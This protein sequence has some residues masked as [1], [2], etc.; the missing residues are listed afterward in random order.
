MNAI[1]LKVGSG[2]ARQQ[3][4]VGMRIVLGLG[5]EL[6]ED[7]G[8]A[9]A[10]P[11]RRTTIHGRTNEILPLG[12]GDAG[13]PKRGEDVI[14]HRVDPVRDR[15][16]GVLGGGEEVGETGH[17]AHV[18][19]G[20]DASQALTEDLETGALDNLGRRHV[21]PIATGSGVHV[22]LHVGVPHEAEDQLARH[23]GTFK[24]DNN[25]NSDVDFDFKKQKNNRKTADVGLFICERIS[26]CQIVSS[27]WSRDNLSIKKNWR[28]K[29]PQVTHET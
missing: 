22:S 6:A 8:E 17:D 15:L 24:V 20:F 25:S 11:K 23:G 10:V 13:L 5:R 2:E 18:G 12:V 16:R 29:S 19:L 14:Q 4:E 28:R 21:G 27:N 7:L 26:C 3:A 1:I 9:I